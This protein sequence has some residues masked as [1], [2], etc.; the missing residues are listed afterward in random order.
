MLKYRSI[1]F[2]I[3][4]VSCNTMHQLVL[5]E[6]RTDAIGGNA[7]YKLVAAMKWNERDPLIL[8]EILSGNVPAFLRKLVPI[9]ISIKD[10]SGGIIHATYFVTPDYLSIGSSSDFART[11]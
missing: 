6:R 9:H 2:L 4:I 11:P 8:K 3:L 5:P 1:I 10:S 7:F